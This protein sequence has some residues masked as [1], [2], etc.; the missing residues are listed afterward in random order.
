MVDVID[1]VLL[2]EILNITTEGA[3]PVI[4]LGTPS[5]RQQAFVVIDESALMAPEGIFF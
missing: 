3:E 4:I 1:T 2:P 5:G